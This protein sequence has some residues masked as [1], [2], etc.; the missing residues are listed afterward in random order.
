MSDFSD[1]LPTKYPVSG[2]SSYQ[3]RLSGRWSPK[4]GYPAGQATK[5][6]YPVGQ[7]TKAGYPAGQ[8]SRPNL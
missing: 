1:I 2:Q 5:V 3:G 8:A 6:D 4:A 7:A